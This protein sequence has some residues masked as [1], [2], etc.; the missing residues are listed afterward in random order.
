MPTTRVRVQSRIV[1]QA[2]R[3]RRLTHLTSPDGLDRWIARLGHGVLAVD[4]ETTGLNWRTE[5][6][7][8]LCLAAGETAIF[9]THGALGP[10]VRWLADEVKRRRT[11]VFH[12]AK[13]D[14]H[15]LRGTFGLHVPYPV[16]D[17]QI[18]SFIVDNRGAFAIKPSP[19]WKL[20]QDHHL[21]S[22]AEVYVDPDAYD[23]EKALM[24]AIKA[25]GG[26]TK[27]DW[28]MAPPKEYAEY[29]AMD[30]WY[31][32]QLHHQFI[33]RIR[34]WMQP[35]GDYP[36]LMEVYDTERWLL[37][38]L[39]DMEE[40]GIMC[41]REF[42]EAWRVELDAKLEVLRR[43]L[44]KLAG[45]KEINWNS[46]PQ[47]RQLLYGPR[48][49]G[50]LGLPVEYWTEPDDDEK[51]PQPATHAVA[52]V[53]LPHKIGPVLKE[54][55][56]VL[57]QHS[58]YAVSL[59][60]HIADDGAIHPTIRQS[61]AET[62]RMS[63]AEPNMQQQTR[64]SG[65]RKAYR[66][67]KGLV[68]RF[69]DYS[70]VEMRYASHFANEET[71]IRGFNEDP[72]FDT[73]RATAQNMYGLGTREPQG[74]Q[75]KFGKILNFTKIFGGGVGKIE[76]QLTNLLEPEEAIAG[77]RELG[78]KLKPGEIP[79]RSLA[80]LLVTYFDSTMP[81]MKKAINRE[82]ELAE[83]RGFVMDAYGGHRFMTERFYAAFNTKVQGS[84]ARQ[85]KKGLVALYRELQLGTGEIA[86]LLQVHDENIYESEGD[87]RTDRKVLELMQELKR[88]KVPIIADMSGS[89]T[90][91]QEKTKVKL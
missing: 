76:E 7:G 35:E 4:T 17:T 49:A 23:H 26:K 38:A 45:K 71:F 20:K 70:Q 59:Q 56:E 33:E 24:A 34:H 68:L 10:M 15:F 29:S 3:P 67:R 42:L 18:E 77:C 91:W 6:V 60:E 83:A 86:L 37:L 12:N 43:R 81:A 48:S 69:A 75:R 47:L 40:R 52:L 50:G 30:P 28:L 84:A 1:Y 61:G 66:P 5:R 79:F 63:C 74:Q 54:Y 14:L 32:L 53:R 85:A 82:R 55:R 13:F 19:H 88:F 31:T 89:S 22:L 78:H 39:R 73:H 65:V 36:P 11:L 41:D 16:H 90:N 25:A 46:V 44:W 62:G 80:Q 58:S 57:K 2:R 21:K 27:G 9:A 64:T 87:P 51:E 72:D 8:G